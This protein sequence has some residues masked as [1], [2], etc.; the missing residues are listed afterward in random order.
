VIVD[1]V[2]VDRVTILE[3][4]DNPPIRANRDRLEAGKF[5]LERVEA[6]PWQVEVRRP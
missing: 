6:K 2:D 4:E 5:F 1:Q 3:P